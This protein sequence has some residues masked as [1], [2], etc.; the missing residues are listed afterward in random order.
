MTRPTMEEVAGW[1]RDRGS[2]LYNKSKRLDNEF[3]Q[4]DSILKRAECWFDLAAQVEDMRW[5]PIADKG[6]PHGIPVLLWKEEWVDEDF[7]PTGVRFGHFIEGEGYTSCGWNACQD[8]FTTEDESY[9]TLWSYLP[10]PPV[11]K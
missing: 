9:P 7:N 8:T 3:G 1:L 10:Q 11:K 2:E 6:A 5:R 4:R